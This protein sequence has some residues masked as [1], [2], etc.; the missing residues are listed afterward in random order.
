MVSEWDLLIKTFN[1]HKYEVTD[2]TDKEFVGI[3]ITRDKEYNYHMDQER[4]INSIMSEANVQS[5]P[6]ARL[7]YPMDGQAL[8]KIDCAL[9]EENKNVQNFLIDISLDNLCTVWFIQW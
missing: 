9:D 7:P 5:I 8:S 4:M 1:G 6:D 2:A 3:R